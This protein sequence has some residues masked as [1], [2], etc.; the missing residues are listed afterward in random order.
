MLSGRDAALL[1]IVNNGRIE[2]VLVING[3]YEYNSP[4]NLVINGVGRFAELTP[5]ISEGQIKKIIVDN[6]GTNYTDTTTISVIASGQ[7]AN[8]SADINQWTINLFEKYQDIIS[9]DDGILE[10][11]LIDEYGIQY[12][13]LYAPR[14]LR[15][16][17]FGQVIS[18]DDGVKYGLTDLRLDSSNSEIGSQFHSPIIGWA[19]DGNPIYGPYGYDTNTGGNVRALKSGY[20]LSQ[21]NNRPPLSSWKQGFFCEDFVFTGEGDLDEHNGRYCVTPDFPNGV[22]AYFATINDGSTES[23]GTFENFKLPQY[24]YFIGNKFK[25]KPND[26]NFKNDSYQGK[27]DIEGNNWLRNTTPYGLTLDNVSYDFVTEPY[28]IFDE[29]IKITS[30]SVGTIDNVGIVTG[31]SGYQ[32]GDRVV[33]ET[34]PGSTSAKAKVFEVSGKVVTNV[35]VASSTVSELE[36][37]PID[38]SGRFVAFS[39]SPHQFTNT[40]LVTLS[41]FNTSINLT[42]NSFNI[43]VSTSFYNLGIEVG[44][45]DVTG[46]VTY[47]SVSG[48]IVDTGELSIRENDILKIGTEK[49]RILNVDRLNS[50]LRVE[51]AVDGTVS[52]AHTATSLLSEQSRKFTFNSNRENKVKFELNN[53]I[54]FDPRESVGV[55]T[56]TGTGVGSTIFFSNPGAGITQVFIENRGIFLPDHNLRTGDVVLYNNGG[57]QSIEVVTNP[58]VGPT[59][60]IANNTSLYVVKISEDIIG[61]QTFKV[62]IGSTGTFVGIADTTMSS[63][64]LSFAGIGTGTKHSIETVKTQVVNAEATRNAVTVATASTHGLSIGDKVKMTVTPG[65]TNSVTVKY[66]D[67][68][69][70]IVFNPLGFATAGVSTEQ[71]TITIIDHGFSTGDKVILDSNPAPSGLEDQK[72]YYVSKFSKDKFKLCETKYESEKFQPNFVPISVAREGNILP[73]NPPLNAFVGNTVVFDLSD[74]SLSSLNAS[75]LYSA[76]DMNLYRDSNYSDRFE[77]SLTNNTFEVKKSGK[78]GIDA[79]ANLTLVVNDNIPK[80][81]FYIFTNANSDFIESTKR[82]LLSMKK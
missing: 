53:Q 48:G 26:F 40:D 8:I 31:G 69:R 77:G 36:I 25:S 78:V 35:S 21:L 2:E 55:G 27:Y 68:N 18:D 16:S 47:F 11:S 60:R 15:Q 17:V 49:V 58:L 28:K 34:L 19:Y 24:P 71:N 80:N 20:K 9:E 57:G 79:N 32:V 52:S 51:R 75:T 61:I 73:I 76:F 72:I 81:L 1:P 62:G 67:H 66:N 38:S 6:P 46:I 70:R 39:D 10:T 82:K 12:T 54:Y 45:T 33:F 59:Y 44:T 74:S 63:G 43:G 23:S 37:A 22:Y 3:G 56:L 7:G 50:R 4:P 64:L 14:K 5:V 41:G 29:V 30:T 65:I 13:H 42:N